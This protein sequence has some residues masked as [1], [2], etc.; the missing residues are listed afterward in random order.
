MDLENSR[1]FQDFIDLLNENGRTAQGQDLSLLGWYVDGLQ[2]QLDAV[3]QE[4]YDVRA[5][6]AAATEDRKPVLTKLVEALQ[7]KIGQV[8]QTLSNF[9]DKIVSCAKNA[10]AR[11]KDAGVSALDNAVAAI[12]LKHGMEHLQ[13]NLQ[14]AVMGARAAVERGEKMGQELR[15]AGSHLRNAARAAAGKETLEPD[16]EREGRFQAAVLAP[17]RGVSKVL[18]IANNSTLAMIGTVERLELAADKARDNQA[19]RAVRKPGRRPAKKPSVRQ[20]LK[21][22]QAEIST[23]SAPAPEKEKKTQEAA[24]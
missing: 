5:E 15:S 7:D 9:K 18:V 23:T 21:T 10:V 20:A 13:E 14:E 8:R 1:S 16:V 24:L 17:V 22:K 12:G 4:L 6:L 19:E 3:T 2:R 11:F